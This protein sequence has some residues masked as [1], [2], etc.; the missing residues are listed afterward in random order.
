MIQLTVV[1]IKLVGCPAFE[2]MKYGEMGYHTISNFFFFQQAKGECRGEWE[3]NK[4][5]GKGDEED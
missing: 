1:G 2:E 5:K 4:R 3:M